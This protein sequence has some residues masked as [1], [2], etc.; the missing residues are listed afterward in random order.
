VAPRVGAARRAGEWNEA[1]IV[2][3]GAQVEHWLNG[4]KVVECACAG[5]PRRSAVTLQNHN[6]EVWFRDLRIRELGEQ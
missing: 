4:E 6:S 1:R 2:V 5:E 3:Q